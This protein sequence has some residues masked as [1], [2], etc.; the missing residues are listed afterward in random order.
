MRVSIIIPTYNRARL[1]CLA[2]DSILAQD[3]TDYEIIVVDDGSTDGTS[4]ALEKYSGSIRYIRQENRGFGA[5]RNRGLAEAKGEYLAF[6]DSDDLWTAGKLSIQVEIMDRLSET[7]FAFSDFTILKPSGD[8]ISEGLR[9]WHKRKTPWEEIYSN[10]ISSHALLT[11]PLSGFDIYTG[12]IYRQLLEEPHVLPSS[13]IVRRSMLKPG[14][15][16]TVGDPLYADWDFF[17]RLARD[18]TVCFLDTAT[19]INRSHDDPVRL[20]TNCGTRKTAE[21]RLSLIDR[22]WKKD[23][24]FMGLHREL[25]ENI[26]AAQL[27]IVATQLLLERKTPEA[28]DALKKISILDKGSGATRLLKFFAYSPG[29][30]AALTAA[31]GLR[32]RIRGKSASRALMESASFKTE[33]IAGPEG[34]RAISEEWDSLAARY[35]SPLASHDWALSCAEAFHD[36]MPTRVLLVRNS[37]KAAA[38]APLGLTGGVLKRLEFLGSPFL[39]EPGA[40]LLDE[41]ESTRSAIFKALSDTGYPAL[42]R[43]LPASEALEAFREKYTA[44]CVCIKSSAPPAP[45]AAVGKDW[46]G[47]H[48]GL[49]PKR[50]YD[51]RRAKKRAEE[52]GR[53]SANI[54]CPEPSGLDRELEKVFRVE[55]AGW[56]GRNGSSMLHNKRLGSFFRAY[57]GRA[58]GAGILRVC[59]LDIGGHT[60]AA[61]LAIESG[62]SFWVL[63][64]G[65]DENWARCSPGIQLTYECMKYAFMRNLVSYEFLGTIEP[66]LKPFASGRREHINVSIY[67][68]SLPGILALGK[69]APRHAAKKLLDRRL[70][71]EALSQE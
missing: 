70:Q 7:A 1:V 26:E 41:N 42:L 44:G 64:I 28:K 13:A 63:K 5:A 68:R 12:N 54:Y 56:K 52:H 17:A 24:E 37:G 35:K 57:S 20:T 45:F 19:A 71:D 51:L 15:V 4:K 40:L 8:L 50:R 43:R 18:H 66:W 32:R 29:G 38:I 48:G 25:V 30:P 21:C 3:Y 10:K 6:L 55:A 62:E 59:T 34:M 23:A 22:V 53:V 46:Y 31:R 69:D 11:L 47:F 27:K 39:S 16:F 61:Q 67:P 14:I 58:C 65:Y 60:A 2:I 33:V 49:S 9:T 36:L